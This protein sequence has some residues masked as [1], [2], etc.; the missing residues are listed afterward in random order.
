MSENK[1]VTLT[2]AALLSASAAN[3][4]TLAEGPGKDAFVKYCS[5]CHTVD[6]VIVN[7]RSADDWRATV[8]KMSGYGA[9]VPAADV[10]VLV[11]YLST[12]YGLTPPP[13]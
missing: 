5:D 8:E 9:N 4:Q 10:D 1:L 3:A 7:R 11:T 2:L 6:S 13:K 12:Y